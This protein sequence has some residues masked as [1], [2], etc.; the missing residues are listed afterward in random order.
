MAH[1]TA[2]YAGDIE[3]IGYQAG[4]LGR[5]LTHT[6]LINMAAAERKASG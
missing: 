1:P 6:T 5:D 3:E 2:R 4:F